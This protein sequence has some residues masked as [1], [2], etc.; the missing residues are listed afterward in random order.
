MDSNNKVTGS[1]SEPGLKR[2]ARTGIMPDFTFSGEGV[3]VGLVSVD[4]PAHKAGVQNGDIIVKVNKTIIK[5]LRHFSDI[6]K[7]FIPGNII[8]VAYKRGNNIIKTRITLSKR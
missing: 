3:Q 8:L 4:S 6:L 5:N 2:R 1:N 7:K